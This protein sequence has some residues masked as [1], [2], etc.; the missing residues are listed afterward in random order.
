VSTPTRLSTVCDG[1]Q[2]V[3]LDDAELVKRGT[4]DEPL[5]LG[6]RYAR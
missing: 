3:V 1:E 4:H 2:V 6:G 5:A